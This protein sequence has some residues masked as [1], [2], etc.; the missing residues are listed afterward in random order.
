MFGDA[1]N[2]SGK[3]STTY[4]SADREDAELGATPGRWEEC[5]NVFAG[6]VANPPYVPALIPSL[7]TAFEAGAR[8]DRAYFRASVLP[9]ARKYGV[10]EMKCWTKKTLSVGCCFEFP[11][12]N[13]N[14]A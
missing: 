3:M 4:G 2:E 7:T 5:E 12:D 8:S 6:G 11:R 13:W 14:Q 10:D 9:V 1:G